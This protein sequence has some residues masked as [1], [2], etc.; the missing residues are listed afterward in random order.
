[1]KKNIK[2]AVGVVPNKQGHI[3]LTKRH[4]DSDH[5][6]L[7]EFP[8]GKFESNEDGFM[9]LQRELK[10]EINI[11]VHSANP[12]LCFSHAY[13]AYCVILDVFWVEAYD[14]AVSANEGQPMCWVAP[15][16]LLQYQLPKANGKIV[17]AIIKR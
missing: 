3:L 12:F 17:E 14:G 11:H 4:A 10:E 1:M 5:G 13:E 15:K 6:G 2:V 16:D 9:A 7:W 8:G